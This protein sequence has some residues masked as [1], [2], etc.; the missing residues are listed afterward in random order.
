MSI[1]S[2]VKLEILGKHH[3]DPLA[4]DLRRPMVKLAKWTLVSHLSPTCLL[5]LSVTLVCHTSVPMSKENLL[6]I[7]RGSAVEK[8]KVSYNSCQGADDSATLAGHLH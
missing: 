4:L 2:V 1:L 6:P 7:A 3:P 5:H 8:E